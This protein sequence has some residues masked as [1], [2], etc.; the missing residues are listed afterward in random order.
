MVIPVSETNYNLIL[1][2]Y[3]MNK[4]CPHC[5]WHN[6][7][8]KKDKLECKTCLSTYDRDSAML[9]EDFRESLLII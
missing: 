5:W 1:N 2:Y 6:F 9:D 8:I 7:V 4:S 3:T